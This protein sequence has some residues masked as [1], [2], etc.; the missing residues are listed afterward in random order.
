MANTK[1][2]PRDCEVCGSSYAPTYYQQRTCGRW[3]GYYLQ[4]GRWPQ[5]RLPIPRQ[6]KPDKPGRSVR[7]FIP[8]CS[9][10]GKTFA[11]RY[12]VTTCSPACAEVKERRD[13]RIIRDRHRA[14]KRDA[15]VANVYRQQIYER[16]GWR[17][18]ICHKKVEL[19]KGG[20]HE[21]ANCRTAHFLC[22]ATRGDRGGDEQLRLIS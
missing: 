3:C 5:S 12:T 9:I 18:Q 2:R 20:T 8:D 22:N 19:A 1:R 10:C 6:A 15:F 11:T 13:R 16:D 17:C 4:N 7:I 21:P 14:R